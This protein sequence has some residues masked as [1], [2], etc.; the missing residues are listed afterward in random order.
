MERERVFVS[1]LLQ[2]DSRGG[3]IVDRDLN[4]L[5]VYDAPVWGDA[6]SH[7]VR[8]RFPM[9]SV[10]NV[11]SSASLSGFVVVIR[12]HERTAALWWLLLLGMCAGGVWYAAAYARGWVT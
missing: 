3:R 5:I 6:Q 9:C 8:V 12:R 10:T 4:S 1:G 7:R 11:A 2:M